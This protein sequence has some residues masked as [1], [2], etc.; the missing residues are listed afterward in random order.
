[1]RPDATAAIRVHGSFP[2]HVGLFRNEFGQPAPVRQLRGPPP[3]RAEKF[4]RV[5]RD[6]VGL[7]S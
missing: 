2:R 4:L 6:R 3:L 1:M 5:P 7:L